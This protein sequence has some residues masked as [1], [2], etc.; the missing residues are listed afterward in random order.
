MS[1][2]LFRAHQ[3]IAAMQNEL[4]ALNHDV[5]AAITELA[6]RRAATLDE[7][8]DS[9]EAVTSMGQDCAALRPIAKGMECSTHAFC[10][11]R[12]SGGICDEAMDDL[13]DVR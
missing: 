10:E 8:R 3:R 7:V 1:D 4:D 6:Q 9:D 13:E 11:I 12:A 5:L 2:A